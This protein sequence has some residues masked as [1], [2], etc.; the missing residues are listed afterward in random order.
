MT[1]FSYVVKVPTASDSYMCYGPVVPD[2]YGVCYNPF[3]NYI[4]FCVSSYYSCD[5]T[6]SGMFAH[7]IESSLLQMRELCEQGTAS[8]DNS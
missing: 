6:D 8:P 4:Y 5:D 7:S 3:P 1:R 2:G